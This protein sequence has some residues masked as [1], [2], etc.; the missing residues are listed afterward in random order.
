MNTHNLSKAFA[1][2]GTRV[3]IDRV[4]NARS[5]LGISVSKDK[6]GEYFSIRVDQTYTHIP[7]CIHIAETN[8]KL[9]Q[10]VIAISYTIGE[11]KALFTTQHFLIGKDEC[12]LFVAGLN[13]GISVKKAFTE[14]RPGSIS[15]TLS[16]TGVKEKNWYKRKNKTFIRQGEWFFIPAAL[17]PISMPVVHKKEP[18]S[19]NA[20]KPHIV[21]ELMRVGGEVVYVK[22][23]QVIT[24]ETYEHLS[25]RDRLR[26]R[27]RVR[28]ARVFVRG[29]VRHPDHKTIFLDGWHEVHLNREVSLQGNEFVD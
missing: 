23:S 5:P 24:K 9:K 21:D 2:I 7:F 18:I 26:T 20:G 28:G 14:L 19:R 17:P 4:R 15:A 6:K 27:Q 1:S 13:N 11:F 25:H 16:A 8:K 12:H 10:M 22:N 3:C 29:Y